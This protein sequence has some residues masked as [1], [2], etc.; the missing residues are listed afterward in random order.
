MPVLRL[1]LLCLMVL[2]LNFLPLSSVSPSRRWQVWLISILQVLYS[3][4]I[5]LN[6]WC[7]TTA[8]WCCGKWDD[9]YKL[10]AG[11]L[12]CNTHT[13]LSLN[14]SHIHFKLGLLPSLPCLGS[15]P[16]FTFN[17]A[18]FTE[19]CSHFTKFPV[20]FS[21]HTNTKRCQFLSICVHFFHLISS[22]VKTTRSSFSENWGS[23][24]ASGRALS[25]NGLL[26]VITRNP[27][28]QTDSLETNIF[29]CFHQEYPK[30]TMTVFCDSCRKWLWM[31]SFHLK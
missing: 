6:S 22:T 29:Y 10:V 19:D 5:S 23:N 31:V 15:P 16:L 17:H 24:L 28:L 27:A 14:I 7:C 1:M 8:W 11:P 9:T 26:I 13:C 25:S 3:S 2:Y 30:S 4:L 18:D 21:F 20:Y 12:Q